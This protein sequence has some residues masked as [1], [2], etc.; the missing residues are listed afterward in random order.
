MI[1]CHEPSP[2]GVKDRVDHIFDILHDSPIPVPF[3][4]SGPALITEGVMRNKLFS[5]L[6]TPIV[7]FPIFAEQM[8]AIE[9][10]NQTALENIAN[11]DLSVQ[12]DCD[13]N[14]IPPWYASN[15][16]NQAVTCSDMIPVTGDDSQIE[17]FYANVSAVSPLVAQIWFPD[18]LNRIEW[19]IETNWRF[20]GPF[21]GI[22]SHPILI[23]ENTYDPV[24]SLVE[25]RAIAEK[26]VGAEVLEHN[27]HGHCTVSSP[28][29]CTA[30]AVRAYFVNGTLPETGTVC[31]P[32]E[33]PFVGKGDRLKSLSKEDAELLEA[34]DALKVAIP[35]LGRRA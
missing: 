12:C 29:L 35:H 25:A 15:Q 6:Y 19:K 10:R 3:A 7:K 27:A 23:L 28:S 9:I 30:K 20:K 1:L 17:P 13:T 32:E 14:D 31:E 5:A 18:I 8:R 2:A 34:L 11:G 24:T 4:S 33:L 21:G 22:T 26:F 16:A